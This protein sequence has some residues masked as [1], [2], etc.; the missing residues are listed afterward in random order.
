ME[1]LKQK[2]KKMW[3]GV[4]IIV[5]AAVLIEL[6]TFATYVYTK[7]TVGWKTAERAAESMKEMQRISEMKA[8]VETAVQTTVGSVEENL[9]NPDELYRI[10][11]KLVHRNDHIIG[12]AV[13]LSPGFYQQGST[14]F[15]AFAFQSNDNSP[16]TTKQLPY[17]YETWEWFATPMKKDTLWWS[18]PYYDEGGSDMLIYTFSA[19]LHNKQHECV[20]VLTADVNFKEMV[21][22]ISVDDTLFDR[23]HLWTLLSQL[24]CMALI[25]LIV[26]RSSKSIRQLNKVQTKQDLMTKEL[27]IASDI[28]KTM[29]PVTS[30]QEDERHHLDIRVKLL[31]ASDVSADLYDY[32]YTGRSLVFC[33]GDV[34][35]NNV[36][37]SMM[38]AVT[39]SVF[40]TAAATVATTSDIPS[41]AAIVRAVNKSLCS[42]QES[43]MFTTLFV[44]VLNLDT[45]CLT[46]CNA[47]HPQPVILSPTDGAQQLEI[48]PNVPVGIVEDYEYEELNITLT[49]D[50]TMFFYTD[51]LYETEN[52]FHELFGMKRMMIRLKKSAESNE[53]PKDIVERMTADVEKF[54]G[55]AK[56]ID[57]AVMVVIKAIG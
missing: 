8:R 40:R 25:M 43:Q 46:Y 38:M 35:G 2:M 44:G 51:G 41:P 42:I 12:S 20:G 52:T 6:I 5:V 21:S 31:S 53:S 16:V 17:D 56:R 47:G 45:D 37:A 48:K 19:P 13:A 49:K 39:R 55:N 27:Q 24:L 11:A 33:L 14:E 36:R 29:L 10:C 1:I 26:W 32:F 15:A 4:T 57:D 22:G 54:R 7:R 23:F 28:Q 34:P 50:S 3:M 18:E 30:Q 9:Q